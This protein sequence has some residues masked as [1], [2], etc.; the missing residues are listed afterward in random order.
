MWSV[1]QWYSQGTRFN[2]QGHDVFYRQEGVGD[3]LVLLHGFPTAS[4]DWHRVWDNLTR[5]YRVIAADF[6]GFG[7]SAKPTNFD[8][9]L[10]SQA[11]MV[12][13]LLKDRGV[14]QYHVLAHDI[15]DSVAQ[16]L[17]ARDLERNQHRIVSCCL[18]NGG[19]FPETHRPTRTQ[20]L[21][22]GPF[23]FMVSRLMNLR[24]FI[25][26]FT[27]LFPPSTRPRPSE[28]EDLYSLIRFNNGTHITHKL[29]QYIVERR[30]NRERWLAALQQARCPLRLIDGVNDPVS[31]QHM[32]DRYK[33]LIPN[34]DVV[35]I[36]DCG[37][38][39][40]WERPDEV[41][42]SY[43]EFRGH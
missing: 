34:P 2:H 41:L 26:S 11:D 12:E 5:H 37:H 6:I 40:Q 13:A 10:K 23:G 22:L 33:E 25:E 35:E 42:K 21:L 18:L 15:G 14:E 29:I 36:P 20:Q 28:L 30:E 38:Y 19:L 4:W 8:Y 43:F 39:P 1:N 7:H 31:G 27:I 3:T 32:V 17:L 24:R 16:E 9:S